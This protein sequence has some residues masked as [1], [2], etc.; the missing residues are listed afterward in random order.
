MSEIKQRRN[1]MLDNL[2]TIPTWQ[3]GCIE[4]MV[5]LD[6]TNEVYKY[7]FSN[8]IDDIK[9]AIFDRID[10][11]IDLEMA[12]WKLNSKLSK[13]VKHLMNY[14]NVNFSMT[15]DIK[16]KVKFIEVNMRVGNKW[17]NTGYYEINGEFLSWHYLNIFKLTKEFIID[18]LDDIKYFEDKNL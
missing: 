11:E 16:G 3:K 6:E 2:L 8:S 18:L 10:Q 1:E 9:T 15:T 14:H 7:S 13:S 4:E 17:F 12:K 5:I